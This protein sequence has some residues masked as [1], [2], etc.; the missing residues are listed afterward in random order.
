MMTVRCKTQTVNRPDRPDGENEFYYL[1]V[2]KNY[3]V[4]GFGYAL[5]SMGYLIM[6]HKDAWYPSF[7]PAELFEDPVGELPWGYII[8][9]FRSPDDNLKTL[10]A[11]P[12]CFELPYFYDRLTDK[13][14]EEVKIWKEFMD[15]IDKTV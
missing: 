7:E 6:P 13:Y 10:V 9:A 15:E 12:K 2:G 1:E 14:P 3:R 8:H 5:K 11:V 4:Y